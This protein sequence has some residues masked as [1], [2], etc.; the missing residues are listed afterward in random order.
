MG[1]VNDI[2]H[3]R[4]VHMITWTSV[5]HVSGAFVLTSHTKEYRYSLVYKLYNVLTSHTKEYRYSLVYKLYKRMYTMD[6]R[7]RSRSTVC[8]LNCGYRHL[9]SD[10]FKVNMVY[11]LK[12]WLANWLRSC[13]KSS[14][15]W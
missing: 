12:N 5:F 10:H 7:T 13:G 1:V 14:F 11:I 2:S 9:F 15:S 6:N 8:E 4:L 3:Y